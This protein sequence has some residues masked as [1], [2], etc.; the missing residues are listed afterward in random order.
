MKVQ[1]IKF[2]FWHGINKRLY[3]VDGIDFLNKWVFTGK[4]KMHFNTGYLMQFTGFKSRNRKEIYQGDILKNE[5]G[6]PIIITGT[7][8]NLM[9]LSSW[10]GD[11]DLVGNIFQTP[12][13]T[14][15]LDNDYTV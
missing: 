2:R 3:R 4:Q 12:E 8:Y 14:K 15:P 5:R 7:A 10:A 13:L 9:G 6:E 1:E 11:C